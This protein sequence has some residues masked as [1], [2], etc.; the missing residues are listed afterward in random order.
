[1]TFDLKRCL[2]YKQNHVQPLIASWSIYSYTDHRNQMKKKEDEK[3][4]VGES[5]VALNYRLSLCLMSM[6]LWQRT[7]S[8]EC[9]HSVQLYSAPQS[10]R[11]RSSPAHSSF[12]LTTLF[13]SSSPSSSRPLCCSP[14]LGAPQLVAA[15]IPI[16]PK[17]LPH[18]LCAVTSSAS[19]RLLEGSHPH[20]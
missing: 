5:E 10:K 15:L 6:G 14:P 19:P 20:W 12:L 2:F 8:P 13:K 18:L 11:S 17:T 7:A 9:F 1:M 3:K 4:W 16:K